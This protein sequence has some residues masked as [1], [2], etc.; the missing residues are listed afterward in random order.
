MNNELRAALDE[1]ARQI[2]Y[3]TGAMQQGR[4]AEY[5]DRRKKENIARAAVEAL[6]ADAV[7][8]AER[9]RRNAGKFAAALLSRV[10]DEIEAEDGYWL[11]DEI[12][13]ELQAIKDRLDRARSAVSPEVTK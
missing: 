4:I 2:Q 13:P 7:K 11:I 12:E 5:E 1:Y 10:L 6:F 3:A 8:D 9:A